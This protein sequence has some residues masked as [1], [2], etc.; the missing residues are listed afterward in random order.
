MQKSISRTLLCLSLCV[1][2]L[3]G[4]LLLGGTL[5]YKSQFLNF[6][7]QLT[8]A[9]PCGAGS[10]PLRVYMYD[11][12]PRFNVGLMGPNF[13]EA[14]PVTARNIPA[15]RWNDGLRRQHSVEYWMM[16]SLLYGGDGE[17]ELTREAV[18]VMDPDSADVF[19][20]PFFSSLSFNVHV[21]NMAQVDTVDEKLQLEMVN[22]L[23][24]SDYWKRSDGRDHVIPMHHPNAFRHYRDLLNAS[25]FIVADFGRIMNISTLAKD[26]VAPYPHMVES[27][28]SEDHQDPY[29]SR[30]TLLFFRGRTHRKDEGIIR[31]QLYKA[32]NGT[33]DIIYEEAH[34]S[35]EGFKASA[36]HMRSSKFCLHP[37]GDTP[38]SCRLFDAIVSHCVP[39]IVSDRI[40]LP[41]ES[42]IDY[43]EFSIFISVDE[44]LKPGYLVNELR[45]VSKEKWT[46][47]WLRL[48]DI[49]HHFEFQSPPKN[50]DAVNMIWRQ[51][52]A[53]VP[54]VKLAVHR[55]RRL[56]IP[57]W[58]R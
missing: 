49:S 45:S 50:E 58:W 52:K 9:S 54:A 8:N 18:R 47:M 40:E 43:K 17:S 16:A 28:S 21:R 23:R 13:P 20:V 57:D 19:F 15:W 26:V 42:E 12:P 31:A 30:E 27:Y 53:K 46:N 29:K 37:A 38:S 33:K 25:I 10:P 24:E 34:A 14:A 56:K 41:Y 32:L 3:I 39:V 51:V 5:D 36:D 44:A 55:S 2:L 22:I 35:E 11:L 4:A 7:P 48:K 1:P 6:I